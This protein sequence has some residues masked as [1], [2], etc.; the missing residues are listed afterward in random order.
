MKNNP[1]TEAL[2]DGQEVKMFKAGGQYSVCITGD[3]YHESQSQ[4][5]STA[6]DD[7][8]KKYAQWK[9]KTE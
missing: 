8:A 2:D 7:V 4:S 5:L 9:E 3:C 1:L 6:I